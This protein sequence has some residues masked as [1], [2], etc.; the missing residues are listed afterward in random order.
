MQV[1]QIYL[2][3][4]GQ[5]PEGL[6]KSFS[7]SVRK[8]FPNAPYVLY[9]NK[10]ADAFL[11]EHFDH[12]IISA[13]KKLVPYAYKSDLLRQ[14]ILLIKGGW[15]VD[16][17]MYCPLPIPKLDDRIELIAFR[18]EPR[19]MP[20]SSWSVANGL[21]YAKPNHPAIQR[22]IENI[23]DNCE[24]NYYGYTPLC[25]TGPMIWGRSLC[26]EGIKPTTY[27]GDFIDLTPLHET[28]NRSMVLPNGRILA[29]YKP[30]Q[31]RDVRQT[32]SSLGGKG[33]NNFADLWQQR[34]IY[35]AS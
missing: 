32:L 5:A 29:L 3:D 24:A 34:R 35:N 9:K 15:Y 14:C 28:R 12:R 22:T 25:P 33:T 11:E 31:S 20:S 16:I 2:T 27:Y 30:K 8:A 1:T 23:V 17:G 10:E 18:E 19:L 4:D 7:Q 21:I 26:E 13:Y 6:L